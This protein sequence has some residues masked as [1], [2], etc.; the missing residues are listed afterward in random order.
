MVTMLKANF[1]SALHI[2]VEERRKVEKGMGYTGDSIYVAGLLEIKKQV[3]AEP[4]PTVL[5]EL[6]E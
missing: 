3:E 4:G 6:K 1:L 5:L 2:A